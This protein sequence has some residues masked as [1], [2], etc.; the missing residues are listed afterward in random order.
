MK[1]YENGIM[2]GGLLVVVN[3]Y[4]DHVIKLQRRRNPCHCGSGKKYR[5]CC[6]GRFR[7]KDENKGED[8]N[9]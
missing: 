6:E 4:G 3:Q 1:K 9:E 7:K 8:K 5:D 2:E